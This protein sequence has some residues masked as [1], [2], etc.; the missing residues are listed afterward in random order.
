M[1]NIAFVENLFMEANALMNEQQFAEAKTQLEALLEIEPGYG[2]AHNHMAWLYENQLQNAEKAG[3][4][5]KLALKF[6]PDYLPLYLN[7]IWF[8]FEQGRYEAHRELIEKA[9]KLAGVNQAALANELGRSAEI[10]GA[11]A[12]AAAQYA[13]AAELSM[14]TEEIAV[15][16][17]NAKRAK[18]KLSLLQRL[19]LALGLQ[20]K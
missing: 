17:A 12:K 19:V 7:Y 18:S 14:N 15:Y 13:R 16:Q 10:S 6:A 1:T 5:Y 8:L 11:M 3:Y 9:S 4:H 20:D 2:R